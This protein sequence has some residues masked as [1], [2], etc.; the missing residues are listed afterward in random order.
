MKIIEIRT[1]MIS[2]NKMY[3]GRRF[4]SKDG[5]DTKTAIAWEIASTGKNSPLEG[6]VALNIIFYVK[7]NRADLDNML[8]ALLDC[9]T[10]TVY[11]DDSQVTEIHC[12]KEI[13]KENPR[14]I[15][16]IL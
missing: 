12:F 6:T 2:V 4:L 3:R 7:N 5:K 13:D 16:Q 10:G 14:T 15:V 1:P 8:K 9:M 11:K